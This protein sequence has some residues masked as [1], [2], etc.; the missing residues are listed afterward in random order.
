MKSKQL[1]LVAIALLCGLVSAIGII[2]AMGNKGSVEPTIPMGPVLVASDHLDHKAELTEEN[3]KLENWPVNLIPEGAA[4]DLAEVN[5]KHITTR[6]RRGQAIILADVFNKEDLPGLAIPPGH[7]VINLKVPPE[8][9]L[10]GLMSPGDRVNIIA[11]FNKRDRNGERR[12]ETKTILRG[13]RVFNIGSN[14]SAQDQR[15]N[16]GS[17]GIVGVLVTEKQ[18]ETIV[19]AKKIGDIRLTLI[20]ESEDVAENSD[21]DFY[22]DGSQP[23]PVDDIA[24]LEPEVPKATHKTVVYQG[25]GVSTIF[26]DENDNVVNVTEGGPLRGSAPRRAPSQESTVDYEDSDGSEEIPVGEDEDQYSAE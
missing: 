11:V 6:L 22:D 25:D 5:G 20:G 3:V 9:T 1:F 24:L 4:G 21:F 13:I 12:S 8:D 10:N 23:D 16:G 7:N 18:S 15:K 2:Q 17:S 14:T 26:F 19:W